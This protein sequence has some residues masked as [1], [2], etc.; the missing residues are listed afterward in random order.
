MLETPCFGDLWRCRSCF[1]TQ[2]RMPLSI[3]FS[4][5]FRR[6]ARGPVDLGFAPTRAERRPNPQLALRSTVYP[7]V[8]RD[9][10]LYQTRSG[11]TLYHN[12]DVISCYP[13]IPRI[14][15]YYV[16]P[17]A[18]CLQSCCFLGDDSCAISYYRVIRSD[19]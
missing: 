11:A 9:T 2:K 4:K 5:R 8:R 15:P 13:V 6:G 1:W 3:L 16:V 18:T 17:F 10:Q 7:T 19:M 14:T 12:S